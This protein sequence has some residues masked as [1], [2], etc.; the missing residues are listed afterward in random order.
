MLPTPLVLLALDHLA[1][2]RG[3][4]SDRRA[5]RQH[6]YLVVPA[7]AAP[8]PTDRRPAWRRLAARAMGLPVPERPADLAEA[9]ASLNVRCA[10]VATHLALMGL[11]ARRLG[12]AE[13]IAL[14]HGCW[15]PGQAGGDQLHGQLRDVTGLVASA[16]APPTGPAPGAR[17]TSSAP[18]SAPMAT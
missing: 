7:A 2:V 8:H 5:M 15:N 14:Y 11:T 1:H 3:L 4:V 16:D 9:R 17:D 13:L 18:P 6:G 10:E 12:W